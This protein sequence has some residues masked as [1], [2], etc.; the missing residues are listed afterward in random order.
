MQIDTA[1]DIGLR[2]RDQRL[3][4]RVTQAELAR[5]VGASRSWVMK[6]ERGNA[7]AEIGLV[8]RA[9]HALGLTVDVREGSA[10][11]GR[12]RGEVPAVDLAAILERARG[13][14]P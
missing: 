5:K 4:L 3:A 11:A 6:M 2:I 7:G 9:L 14:R 10:A 8:L 1:R 13:E 12:A